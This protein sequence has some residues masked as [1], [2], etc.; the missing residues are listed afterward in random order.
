M[1]SEVRRALE[2]IT[3]NKTTG[4]DKLPTE[5]ITSAGEAAITEQT[6]LCHQIWIRNFWPKEWRRPLF[7]PL[8]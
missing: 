2:E 5:L 3:G 7:L 4:V 6:A 8:P 1:K